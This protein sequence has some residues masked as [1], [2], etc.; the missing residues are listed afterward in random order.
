VILDA[1]GM[2]RSRH[3]RRNL[4]FI[5]LAATT[6]SPSANVG[7]TEDDPRR[8]A[9]AWCAV[10]AR[11]ISRETGDVFALLSDG[12]IETTDDAG[13]EFGLERVLHI[14]NDHGTEPLKSIVDNLMNELGSFGVQLDDQTILAVR[15]L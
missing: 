2:D 1:A 7:L 11:P 5:A 15:V 9:P 14:L 4:F 13:S 3:P 8:L 12:I 6:R 10:A